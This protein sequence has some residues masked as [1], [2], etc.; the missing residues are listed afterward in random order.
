MPRADAPALRPPRDRLE[1][2]GY[3]ALLGFVSVLQISIA[4]AG[5]LLASTLACWAALV[6]RGR[7]RVRVPASFWPLAAYA[8][9]TLVAAAFSVDPRVSLIDCKQL[10]LFL[11]VPAAYRLARGRRGL[12]V[13]EVVISVGAISA[14]FGIVQYGILNYDHLGRRPQGALTHYMTY[15]GL[16]MLV[17]CAAAA[18]VLFRKKD[19]TWP[20]LVMPALLVA[21]AL[22]FTRSA[23]IGACAGIALLLILKDFRLLAA[24][25]VLVAIFVVFAPA[26]VMD[27]MYSMFDMNDPTNRDRRAMMRSGLHMIQDDPLTGVG[28]DMVPAVYPRYRDVLAVNA[29]NPHLHNVPLQIAAER[30]VPALVAWLWFVVTLTRDLARRLRSSL[31]PSLAAGGLAAIASMLSAGLFE[32]NFGDSEF[33]MMLLVLVTL[34]YAADRTAVPAAPVHVAS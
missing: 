2:A 18:H 4:A 10:L 8:A 6:L 1:V 7:E 3:G 33:L 32:Y 20:A 5:I 17:V 34:P 21:L 26:P 24:L 31:Y 23:W 12:T 30:G 13:V 28:P 19:R 25:P 22:T 15:S 16:L 9:L 14:A 11:V 29:V 27:R